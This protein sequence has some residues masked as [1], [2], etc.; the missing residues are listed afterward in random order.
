[1]ML[2]EARNA[3]ALDCEARAGDV[4]SLWTLSRRPVSAHLDLNRSRTHRD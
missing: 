3:Q 1:M 4:A 2:T